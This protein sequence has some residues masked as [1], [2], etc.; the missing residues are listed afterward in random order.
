MIKV[1]VAGC[2]GWTGGLVAKK[3]LE[4]TEFQLTGAIARK[5]AGRDVGEL[6]IGKPTGVRVSADLSEAMKSSFDVLIDYTKPDSI[7]ARVMAALNAK[8]NVVIG[9]SGLSAADFAEIEKTALQNNVGVIAAGNFSITAALVKHFSLIAAKYIPS[10][11][12][13]DYAH[14]DKPDAPSG[15]TRELAE[16]LSEIAKNHI[17]VP[18]EKTLGFKDARGAS[19]KGTQV[20]SVRLPGF[21][22]AFETIFG[23][24]NE[25]LTIRHD[26]GSGADPYVAG[27]LLAA[28]KVMSTKGLVR[29]LDALLFQEE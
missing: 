28:K 20:H 1:C 4:S 26:A 2:T 3:I 27:T 21:T 12:V 24:P 18:I 6:L 29:G 23:L 8:V 9:T 13:I 10:W 16:R 25:R 5:S 7:K 19:I 17:E 22:I 11:E 14:D 15:T